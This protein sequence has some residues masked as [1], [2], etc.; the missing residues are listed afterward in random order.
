MD[1]NRDRFACIIRQ[2]GETETTAAAGDKVD[3]EDYC[4]SPTVL[5]MDSE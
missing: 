5:Q 1:E 2:T 4:L 3:F